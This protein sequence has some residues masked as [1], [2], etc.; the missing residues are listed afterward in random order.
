[1]AEPT[2][3]PEKPERESGASNSEISRNTPVNPTESHTHGMERQPEVSVGEQ[4]RAQIRSPHKGDVGRPGTNEEIF[5]GS[6]LKELN[7]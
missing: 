6:K 4:I 3:K 2:R 1:M 7:D 5:Q